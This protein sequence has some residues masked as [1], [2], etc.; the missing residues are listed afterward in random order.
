MEGISHEAASFAGTHRLEKLI[1]FYDDNNIS[2]DGEV[3]GWFYRRYAAAFYCLRM[4]RD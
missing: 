2:I 3:A 4:A 1:A